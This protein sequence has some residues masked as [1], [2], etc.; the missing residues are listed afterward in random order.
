MLKK[1]IPEKNIDLHDSDQTKIGW[2][3]QHEFKPKESRI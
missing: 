2:R 3:T 1:E